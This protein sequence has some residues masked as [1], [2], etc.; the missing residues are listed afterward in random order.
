MSDSQA[1][2]A[3][4]VEHNNHAISSPRPAVSTLLEELDDTQVGSRRVTVG[5]LTAHVRAA[6]RTEFET[7]VRLPPA[8]LAAA[9]ASAATALVRDKWA[10]HW[11]G[12]IPLKPEFDTTRLQENIR[13]CLMHDI[14]KTEESLRAVSRIAVGYALEQVNYWASKRQAEIAQRAARYAAE[15]DAEP[16]Y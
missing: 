2:T 8:D 11:N 7:A 3:A 9:A 14:H 13:D 16:D 5:R 15:T 1:A 6:L 4:D 12:A 10:R